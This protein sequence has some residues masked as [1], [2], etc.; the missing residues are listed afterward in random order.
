MHTATITGFGTTLLGIS[1]MD[2]DAIA[3]ATAWLTAL[4]LPIVPL[5]RYRVQFREDD[6]YTVLDEMP[7]DRG[8]VLRTYLFGWLVFPLPIVGPAVSQWLFDVNVP[9]PWW[10]TAL[11]AL[12]GLAALKGWHDLRRDPDSARDR[13]DATV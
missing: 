3:T 10:W 8:E 1:R 2:E 9:G 6:R 4:W 5:K 11:W 12:V 13:S 7:V